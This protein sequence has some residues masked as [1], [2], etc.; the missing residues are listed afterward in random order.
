MTTLRES[1]LLGMYLLITNMDKMCVAR[2]NLDGK[3]IEDD[4]K[5]ICYGI[6]LPSECHA[7]FGLW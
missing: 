5:I 6:A 1:S 4:K 7:F 2:Y 3:G